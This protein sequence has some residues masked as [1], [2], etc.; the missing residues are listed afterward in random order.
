MQQQAKRYVKASGG[1]R[2]G[3]TCKNVDNA[4]RKRMNDAT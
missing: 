1:I 3:I 2:H 4:K